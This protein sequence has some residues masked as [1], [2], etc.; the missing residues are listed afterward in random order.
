[1]LQIRPQSNESATVEA[2]SASSLLAGDNRDTEV[3]RVYSQI[4]DAVMDRRLLPGAKLTESTL[5]SVFSCSRATVRAALSAL[6]HDKIV[7]LEANRGAFV[8][9]PSEK[10][11]RD[12]FELRRDIESLILT[13]LS[14]MPDLEAR[15]EA[16]YA[17]VATERE[18][19]ELGDR[20]SWIRLSNAFHVELARCIGNDELTALMHTLCARTTLIIAFHDS[21]GEK[22]CS[23]YEHQEILQ[24]L[25]QG[26]LGEAIRAMLHH[27]S[28]CEHRMNESRNERPSNPWLAF[29]VKR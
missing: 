22:A 13:R 17:M 7:L 21:P 24:Q 2:P 18:A 3:G 14:A 16:L 4:F 19:Y 15:L 25:S 9:Q 26:N 23:F 10:E 11:T 8:W 20:I 12:V 1:M 28:D 5:C 27:L 29:S 6:A